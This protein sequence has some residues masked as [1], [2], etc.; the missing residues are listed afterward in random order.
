MD[1]VFHRT[2]LPLLVLLLFST[3]FRLMHAQSVLIPIADRIGMAEL[4]LEGQ[5][6]AT[7]SFR[8]P[9]LGG[10]IGTRHSVVVTHV[11]QGKIRTDSIDIV[12]N[13]G[14]IDDITQIWS[15]SLQMGPG[16]KGIFLCNPVAGIDLRP[17]AVP[18]D[19]F[20]VVAGIQ[21]YFSYPIA[22]ELLNELKGLASRPGGAGETAMAIVARIRDRN[23]V[24]KPYPRSSQRRKDAIMIHDFT[25]MVTTAGTRALLT[26]AGENFGAVKGRILFKNADDG[27]LSWMS[28]EPEDIQFWSE[29][30]IRVWVPSMGRLMPD[31]LR[32]CAGSGTIMVQTAGAT[33]SVESID[34]LT[35]EY[36]IQNGRSSL[37]PMSNLALLIDSNGV[38]GYTFRY[39]T[40][41]A[42]NTAAVGAFEKALRQ[43]RCATGVNFNVGADTFGVAAGVDDGVHLVRW[44]KLDAGSAGVTRMT[45]SARCLPSTDL[46]Y[47]IVNIDIVFDSTIHW[48]PTLTWHFDTLTSP[49]PTEVDFWSTALHELGHAH[50]L[51]HVILPG[52]L[53]H[54][55]DMPGNTT[56]NFSP[57]DLDAGFFVMDS[58]SFFRS[59]FCPDTMS[60]VPIAD[61]N[62]IGMSVEGTTVEISS[63]ALFPNPN[64]GAKEIFLTFELAAGKHDVRIDVLDPLGKDIEQV[65]EGKCAG[66]PHRIFIPQ[67]DKYSGITFV[68]ITVNDKFAF[69]KMIS[70]R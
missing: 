48:D 35:I 19:H 7:K 16:D 11:F 2:G 56:R 52:S 4:I 60:R 46:Y 50:Q 33:D 63:I 28:G 10:A 38:G 70:I 58:S 47:P 15:H 55:A 41:F 9:Q 65:F 25:P 29:D 27:G 67:S 30:T 66:G 14:T 39:D 22:P 37:A 40:G 18:H 13:G 20:R 44:G 61:C 17:A 26:I 21:G 23:V 64:M 12:S 8:D 54:Y 53:M 62:D 3:H 31:S 51:R 36:A 1:S 68:R 49:G 59:A 6:V 32:G 43:W 34:E 42:S 24:A 69:K 57:S 45:F 5:V